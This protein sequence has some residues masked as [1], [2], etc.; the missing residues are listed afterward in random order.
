MWILIAV[1]VLLLIAETVRSNR[2]LRIERVEISLDTL[3]AALDGLK[4]VHLTD[5][6]NRS[7]GKRNGWIVRYIRHHHPDLILCTGDMIGTAEKGDAAFCSLLEELG[8]HF[9]VFCSLGNHELRRGWGSAPEEEMGRC[10][11]RGA[12]ILDNRIVTLA[13]GGGRL[14]IGG[15]CGP[16]K[17]DGR[18]RTLNHAPLLPVQSPELREKLGEKPDGLFTIL[19]AHDPAGFPA[20][21]DWGAELSLSGHLHGG[22]WRPFGIGLLS[23]ARRLFPP[24]S[25]GLFRRGEAALY[26]SA[27]LSGSFLPRLFNRPEIAVLTLCAAKEEKG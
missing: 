4:I 20:Y 8:N 17:W 9:P 2:V 24:C 10:R 6:H 1:I 19:L 21:A 5:L 23:P 22:L 12:V 13:R 27:G 26:V 3:P 7:F 16:L 15:Y 11:E 14:A 18:E 25:A